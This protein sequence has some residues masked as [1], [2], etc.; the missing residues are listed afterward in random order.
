MK[1]SSQ[2]YITKEDK[3]SYSI[4]VTKY[5]DGI[6]SDR[7]IIP[8]YDVRDGEHERAVVANQIK[9]NNRSKYTQPSSSVMGKSYQ[10]SYKK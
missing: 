5:D 6:K 1:T 7:F 3:R 10:T 8:V 9:Q 2:K 4:E